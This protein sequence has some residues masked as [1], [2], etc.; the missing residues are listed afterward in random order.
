MIM[1][2]SADARKLVLTSAAE[3]AGRR[4]DRR[5][6]TDHLLLGLLHDAD[7]S[8]ARALGVSLESA[9]GA[10]DALDRAALAA[11]GVDVGHLGVAPQS[12]PAPARRHRPL[13]S[14]A[15]AVMKRTIEEARPAKTGRIDTSHFLL[16]LLSRERPDPAAE[17][18]HALGVD[19]SAVRDRLARPAQG[20]AA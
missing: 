19:V 6:G 1:R 17:L 15:R 9:R 5:L 10:S 12:A 11:V 7:S 20:D 13:T 16:A 8:A 14:G 2:L 18:L 4:G 3:E